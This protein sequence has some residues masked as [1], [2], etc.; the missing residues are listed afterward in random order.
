M[1]LCADRQRKRDSSRQLFFL[2]I[3]LLFL[4][5]HSH[6]FLFNI[7]NVYDLSLQLVGR[8]QSTQFL[9]SHAI[10]YVRRTLYTFVFTIH[11]PISVNVCG[12]FSVL[13]KLIILSETSSYLYVICIACGWVTW[14]K[15]FLCD[16]IVI[17]NGY[18]FFENECHYVAKLVEKYHCVRH[19]RCENRLNG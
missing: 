2:M 12:F 19:T 4:L 14:V 5:I 15:K 9:Y 8:A 13:N 16:M 7:L 11:T 17:L 3:F 1:N 18:K 6:W 10:S